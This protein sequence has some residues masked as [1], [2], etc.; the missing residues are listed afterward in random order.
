[1]S[2]PLSSRAREDLEVL[3][4][5]VRDALDALAGS[6]GGEVGRDLLPGAAAL[7]RLDRHLDEHLLDLPGC[8]PVTDE[9]RVLRRRVAALQAEVERLRVLERRVRRLADDIYG[10]RDWSLAEEDEL[11]HIRA[12]IEDLEERLRL[13]TSSADQLA[14]A[15]ELSQG[16][17]R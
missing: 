5:R 16:A 6:P 17:R 12:W 11:E 9:V 7:W 10:R 13:E 2:C 4:G 3:Q 14:R 15:V 8:D 1:M